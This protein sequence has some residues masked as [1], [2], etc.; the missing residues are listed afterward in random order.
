MGMTKFDLFALVVFGMAVLGYVA[1][2]QAKRIGEKFEADFKAQYEAD[3]KRYGDAADK[4]RRD[5]EKTTQMNLDRYNEKI[6]TQG[7]ID[8]AWR[9]RKVYEADSYNAA[10]NAVDTDEYKR[11]LNAGI[12]NQH[13]AN[14]EP[15]CGEG[16]KP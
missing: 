1:C 6:H 10:C 11:R 2:R 9:R 3:A 12:A 8:E 13:I 15:F 5:H 4:V 16:R 7:E 14:M